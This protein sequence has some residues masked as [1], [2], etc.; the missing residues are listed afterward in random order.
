MKYG[1]PQARIRVSASTRTEPAARVILTVED[2]GPGVPPEAV[3]HLFEKFFRVARRGEGSRR[4]LGIGLSVVKGLTE[5][6]GGRVTT[7][8]GELGGLAID[9]D[10]A[11]AVEPVDEPAL[12]VAAVGEPSTG[13]AAGVAS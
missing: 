12:A 9:L 2:N 11:A 1:G 13:D 4:G 8:T 6:M 5:A 3:P 10:L 7:R